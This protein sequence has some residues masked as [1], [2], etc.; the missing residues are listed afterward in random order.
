MPN[1][2]TVSELVALATVEGTS[3][4]DADWQRA[5]MSK[6]RAAELRAQADGKR[7]TAALAR[8]AGPGLSLVQGGL[9]AQADV[10]DRTKQI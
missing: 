2:L 10:L 7:Q 3:A 1:A 8:R 9:K 5:K 6:T 4:E